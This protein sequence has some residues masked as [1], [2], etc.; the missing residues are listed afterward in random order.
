MIAEPWRNL[1]NG[2]FQTNVSEGEAT[3]RDTLY[4]VPVNGTP[5]EYFEDY[6][7]NFIRVNESGEP[8]DNGGFYAV[9]WINAGNNDP[10]VYAQRRQASS[11]STNNILNQA[12]TAMPNMESV[13]FSYDCG[14]KSFTV[15]VDH[16]T[17]AWDDW[18][19]TA[20]S[21]SDTDWQGYV[22]LGTAEHLPLWFPGHR[23]RSIPHW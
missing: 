7:S 5:K 17:R 21:S 2:I 4:L 14:S 11:V 10:A 19:R 15:Q 18:G 1:G 22:G 20:E 9:R 8:D 3:R 23:T 13:S 6:D 12:P 16:D